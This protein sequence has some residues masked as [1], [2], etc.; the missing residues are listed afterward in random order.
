LYKSQFY[1]NVSACI[2]RVKKNEKLEK[3]VTYNKY[4]VDYFNPKRT[5]IFVDTISY[6]GA[7]SKEGN[8]LPSP[9][10]KTINGDFPE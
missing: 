8:I 2:F 9:V 7:F 4:T 3:L 5:V 1:T 6:W 10:Y